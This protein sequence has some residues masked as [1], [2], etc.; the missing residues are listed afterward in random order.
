ML[1]ERI[2]TPGLAQVAYLVADEAVRE[3]AVIDPRRDI[4][5]YLA[6]ANERG[7]R[8]TAILETHVHA[9]FVSG[10]PEL[11]A[12]TGAPIHASWLGEQTFPHIPM[13]DGDRVGVGS[14]ALEA[15][16]TPG[17]TPEHIAFL[18]FETGDTS[19]PSALFSG[20]VLFVGDVGR[21]DL[22]GK[23]Q[24]EALATKLYATVTERLAGLH[25]DVVVYP[26]HTA[27]SSCGKKI[28][29]APSTTIGQERK[30]NYA[31]QAQTREEFVQRVLDG[32]PLAPTYYPVLKKINKHGAPPL[33]ALPAPAAF[34]PAEMSEAV[35]AGAVLIDTRPTDAFAA[36]HVPGAVA[37][38]LGPNFV[39]WMG[40]LAPYERDQLLVLESDDRIDEAATDLRRIGLDR[41]RGYLAGG[42]DSWTAA[43]HAT[44]TLEQVDVQ[45]LASEIKRDETMTVLDVRSDDEW[46]G[47]HIAGARHLFAGRIAQG[48]DPGLDPQGRVALICGSGYRSAFAASLL[49]Q[50]GYCRL[51]NVRGG[52]DAWEAAGLPILSSRPGSP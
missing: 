34:A 5:I 25:D 41:V 27:G 50:R 21:P 17:H 1:I 13:N 28:G 2:F 47:G 35:T 51:I 24:T 6:W 45:E 38:G 48:E 36:G 46:R 44:R 10:A 32:M 40:W 33:D 29:D 19:R 7:M 37:A 22:L 15:F 8:I 39:T 9:D 3:M 30:D 20:D 12:A 42:I 4:G 16:W 43:G 23:E 52:M 31:F 14:G 11:A 26:G 49:M 18:L